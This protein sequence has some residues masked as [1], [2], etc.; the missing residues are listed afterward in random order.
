MLAQDR[1]TNGAIYA[2]LALALV[3]VFAVTR[4]IFI[5]QGEFVVYGALTLAMIQT[6]SVP[7]TLWLL[8]GAG[9]LA[10]AVDARGAL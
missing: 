7:A 3:L 10:T 4:V 5:P 2:L 8:V 1:I 6:G 9:V